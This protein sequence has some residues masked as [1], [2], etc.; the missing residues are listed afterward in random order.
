MGKIRHGRKKKR[1]RC[2]LR[3]AQRLNTEEP[4]EI[5]NAPHSFVFYRG[6]TVDSVERLSKD[7]RKVMEPFTASAL[8]AS[9]ANRIRDFLSVS[10]V[11]HVSHMCIFSCSDCITT[12]KIG[13]VPRGP[14]LYLKIINYSLAKDVKSSLKKQLEFDEQ[15]QHPPLVI[16][17]NFGGGEAHKKIMASMFQNMFPP[18]NLTKVCKN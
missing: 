6:V 2:T 3:N 10:G 14:T 17:N 1:G 18:L 4:A 5:K 13:R 15:F 7:F 9:K 8:Q 16:L 12:L 11:L